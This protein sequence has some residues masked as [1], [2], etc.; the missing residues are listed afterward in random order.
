MRYTC[1]RCITSSSHIRALVSSILNTK[2]L[3]FSISNIKN[4]TASHIPNTNFFQ[5]LCLYDSNSR[6][7][8]TKILKFLII[9]YSSGSWVLV[10]GISLSLPM[11]CLLLHRSQSPPFLVYLIRLLLLSLPKVLSLSLNLGG[12]Q[13]S[14]F[15]LSQWG[16]FNIAFFSPVIVIGFSGSGLWA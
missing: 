1:I 9:I 5:H 2:F 7:I 8:R 4:T 12:F 13:R 10:S 6:S 3:A 15:S 14:S 11:C 16:G